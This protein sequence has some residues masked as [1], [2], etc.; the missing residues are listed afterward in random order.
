M[1]QGE[2][3][4]VMQET[5]A[6]RDAK[7]LKDHPFD[8]NVIRLGAGLTGAGEAISKA[9]DEA[10]E[11]LGKSIEP[12]DMNPA[13]MSHPRDALEAGIDKV[14]EPGDMKISNAPH[15]VDKAI[16]A[17]NNKLTEIDKAGVFEGTRIG[18]A[19]AAG[20]IID[21]AGPGGKFKVAGEVLDEVGDAA[22]IAKAVDHINDAATNTFLHEATEHTKQ[23]LVKAMDEYERAGRSAKTYGEELGR[24]EGHGDALVK[25]EIASIRLNELKHG[26]DASINNPIIANL[27]R[28]GTASEHFY[29]KDVMNELKRYTPNQAVNHEEVAAKIAF[30]ATKQ[31]H[32]KRLEFLLDLEGQGKALSPPQSVEI[33]IGKQY[34]PDA[35]ANARDLMS[36]GGINKV[37]DLY[38][39]HIHAGTDISAEQHHE[40]GKP[41]PMSQNLGD[42]LKVRSPRLDTM[43]VDEMRQLGRIETQNMEKL[44]QMKEAELTSQFPTGMDRRASKSPIPG[45]THTSEEEFLIAKS[46]KGLRSDDESI[47]K[48]S[49]SNSFDGFNVT[50]T[51][52]NHTIAELNAMKGNYPKME[53]TQ[54][55]DAL[56]YMNQ[57]QKVLDSKAYDNNPEDMRKLFKK[58]EQ[59]VNSEPMV[60][61]DLNQSITKPNNEQLSSIGVIKHLENP[62]AQAI[63]LARIQEQKEAVNQRQTGAE[64][65]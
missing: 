24:H 30:D 58:E 42:Y 50:E 51:S 43:S 39:D 47:R 63:V 31:A 37:R 18:A 61:S 57:R 6:E 45:V 35:A 8:G 22:K 10:G 46:G 3:K 11:L 14:T 38:P 5:D 48:F 36:N 33:N 28:N 16:A 32:A 7:F 4:N 49:E 2:N 65:T 40:S 52:R 60:K 20:V 23:Q 29:S 55:K 56:E 62:E 44:V 54:Y 59:A 41:G 27:T 19:V 25:F 12:G 13:H 15:P 53:L 9:I 64:L 21:N 34:G 1:A 26:G 17:A